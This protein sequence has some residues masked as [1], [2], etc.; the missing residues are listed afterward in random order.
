MI[1]SATARNCERPDRCEIDTNLVE[2]E[3]A[4][5]RPRPKCET[6]PA[7]DDQPEPYNPYAETAE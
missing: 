4:S 1:G 6:Q 7:K 5:D 2:K 3:V